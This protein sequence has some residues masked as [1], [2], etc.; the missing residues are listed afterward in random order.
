MNATTL[1]KLRNWSKTLKE[2]TEK[3]RSFGGATNTFNRFIRKFPTNITIWRTSLKGFSKKLLT[4]ATRSPPLLTKAR[5][6]KLLP[7][8]LIMF[9]DPRSQSLSAPRIRWKEA[10]RRLIQLKTTQ[11]N[12]RL[13]ANLSIKSCF[14]EE[15]RAL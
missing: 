2:R 13:V 14:W 6:T 8:S 9:S 5:G 11:R 1:P 15:M 3:L 4:I 10:A 12:L 7:R